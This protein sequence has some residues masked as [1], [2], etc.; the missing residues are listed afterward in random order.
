MQTLTR[1]F[2]IMVITFLT[3]GNVLNA[4]Q[5]SVNFFDE[6]GTCGYGCF[7]VYASP[8]DFG[9]GPFEYLWSFGQNSQEI[10]ICQ[11]G[12]YSVTIV[13][14]F[15]ESIDSTFC[16]DEIFEYEPELLDDY[17][18]DETVMNGDSLQCEL[19]CL[20]ST[21]TY[22]TLGGLSV[23]TS[24]YLNI[25]NLNGGHAPDPTIINGGFQVTWDS[26][27][28]YGI[29]LYTTFTE[30]PVTC[31][32]LI[33]ECVSVIPPPEASIAST[34]AAENGTL[35]VCES[36][37]VYFEYTGTNADSLSWQFGDGGISSDA[38]PEYTYTQ[39][40]N[41]QLLLTAYNDCLCLDTVYLDVVV[42]ASETPIVDCVGTLCEGMMGTYTA[43]SSC[44]TFHWSV[45]D[46]GTIVD[47]GGEDENYITVIWNEGP[48]G[49]IELLT[50]DCSVA[51]CPEP[52]TLKVPIISEAV[53]INGPELVCR[54]E[55]S[56]Y[57]IPSYEG[58]TINWT[59]GSGIFLESGQGT[60]E[61]VVRWLDD[62]S[63]SQPN[64]ITVDIENCYLG[65][66]GTDTIFVNVRP[67]FYI[68]GELE[69][70]ANSSESYISVNEDN[71]APFN[72]IWQLENPAGDVVWQS[73]SPT[74]FPSVDF[75]AS[76]GIYR[77]AAMPADPSAF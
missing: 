69:V 6:G 38:N 19:V 11:P 72:A 68:S 46:N 63:F 32:A 47:G 29:E 18:C 35:N 49:I 70:C 53:E 42:E 12:C 27:G 13:N 17:E 25:Y 36:Q 39:A 4:Q 56:T 50:E 9:P 67:R 65:C 3:T 16:L 8:E 20:G 34:P 62:A 30:G 44:N 61:I 2:A 75:P 74:A 52:V 54:G 10:F 66:N 59:V 45:S 7:L 43:S 26:I 41:Y 71:G 33:F 31:D 1:F 73:A 48:E 76:A 24:T 15:G 28:E 40:G 58:T 57:T 64:I 23:D 14:Q 51:S 21:V 55:R 77:L 5:P 37:P 60:N 22:S